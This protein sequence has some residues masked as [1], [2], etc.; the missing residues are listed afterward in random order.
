[1]KYVPHPTPPPSTQKR[2]ICVTVNPVLVAQPTT[3]RRRFNL[4]GYATDV[5]ILIEKV[6]H[7]PERF[8]ESVRVA[9]MRHIEKGCISQ[10]IIVLSEESKSL[11]N[12]YRKQYIRNHFDSTSLDTGKEMISKIAA[13][14]KSR[15]EEIITSTD[16]TGNF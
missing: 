9:S 7:N 14:N 10:Y 8:V 1:M 6:N 15:W 4:R 12:A 3:F 11:Y 16:R 5:V 2:H 13:E